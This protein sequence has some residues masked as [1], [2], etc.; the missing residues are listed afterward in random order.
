VVVVDSTGNY[1]KPRA[2]ATAIF[3]PRSDRSTVRLV[4][5]LRGGICGRDRLRPVDLSAGAPG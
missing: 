2:T 3:K 1:F 4:S 5:D